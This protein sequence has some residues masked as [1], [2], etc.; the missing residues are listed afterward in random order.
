MVGMVILFCFGC[1]SHVGFGSREWRRREARGTVPSGAGAFMQRG[2]G[3][4]GHQG[5]H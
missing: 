5:G 2:E 1:D 4:E 3:K